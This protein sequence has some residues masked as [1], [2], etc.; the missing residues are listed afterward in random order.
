MNRPVAGGKDSAAWFARLGRR[1][2]R[3][4]QLRVPVAA[5]GPAGHGRAARPGLQSNTERYRSGRNGGASKASCPQ[6]HVG[7][8][9]TLSANHKLFN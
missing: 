1:P 8:N 6:G 9:P 4:L 7:S 5:S 2:G 3:M